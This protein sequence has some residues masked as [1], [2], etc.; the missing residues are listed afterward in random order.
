M[1][2]PDHRPL[3]VLLIPVYRLEISVVLCGRELAGPSRTATL[4]ANGM[5]V[6]DELTLASDH[7]PGGTLYT[8]KQTTI[9]EKRIRMTTHTVIDNNH[10]T[11]FVLQRLTVARDPHTPATE[12]AELALSHFELLSPISRPKLSSRIEAILAIR[13]AFGNKWH[14]MLG[15]FCCTAR[16]WY[17]RKCQTDEVLV[18]SVVP[19]RSNRTVF[20]YGIEPYVAQHELAHACSGCLLSLAIAVRC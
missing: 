12:L 11:L 17:N 2:T 4:V 8:G 20:V 14:D 7:N 5:N 13:A 19:L 9:D 16:L 6:H 3:I 18:R 15:A 10:A 1:T